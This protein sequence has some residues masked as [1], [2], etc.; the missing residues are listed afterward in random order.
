MSLAAKIA[1]MGLTIFWPVYFGAEPPIGSNIDIPSGLIFAPAAMPMPPWSIAPRSVIISPN[2]FS[3]TITS[4][5]S[6][7]LII[8]IQRASMWA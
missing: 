2:M 7:F 5:L 6:G 8:H 4:N 1:P 3:V